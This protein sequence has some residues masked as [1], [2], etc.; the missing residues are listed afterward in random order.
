MPSPVSKK[1]CPN[2]GCKRPS[3]SLKG[4]ECNSCY[5]LAYWHK[6]YST[7]PVFRATRTK[8]Q[9]AYRQRCA[10]KS[11]AKKKVGLMYLT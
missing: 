3:R 9:R 2:K 4:G 1:T 10:A 11:A 5:Q 6:R 7:D 8:Y